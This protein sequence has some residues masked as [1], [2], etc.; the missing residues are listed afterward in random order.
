MI[1][2]D[3][4]RFISFLNVDSVSKC[5]NWNGSH[6]RKGYA[7][8]WWNNKTELAMHFSYETFVGP[9]PEGLEPDHLC[10]NKGCSNPDHLEAVTRRENLVRGDSPVGINAR[11][12]HCT[13]GHVFS[14]ENTRI[15]KDGSRACRECGRINAVK[16]YRKNI[17]K[18]KQR[19]RD[20]YQRNAD[21][22]RQYARDYAD[23]R[24]A[25]V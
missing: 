12:T 8:F 3:L 13:N 5:W 15:N 21:K 10:K 14:T 11:K 23:A 7:K 22:C 25:L 19:S 18:A 16:S 17:E 6:T 2:T 1:Q 24:K 9:I 20:Y 4:F